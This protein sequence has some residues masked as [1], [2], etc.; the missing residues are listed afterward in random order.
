MLEEVQNIQESYGYAS[1]QEVIRSLI[2]R[3]LE[4]IRISTAAKENSDVL[5][6]MLKLF[7]EE[8]EETGGVSSSTATRA[9]I[10]APTP[11]LPFADQ[12]Q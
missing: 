8:M 2:S 10:S 6:Q 12:E 11:I 7:A 4:A 1:R 9:D 3:G 5:G